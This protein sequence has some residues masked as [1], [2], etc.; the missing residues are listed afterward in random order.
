MAKTITSADAIYMLT[1]PSIFPVPQQLQGFAADDVFSTDAQQVAQT[2]MGVDGL[3]SAGFVFVSVNQMIAL[4]ADSDSNVLFD[5]WQEAQKAA[6]T[7]F[8]AIGL[9]I[10]PS[11]QRKWSMTKGILKTY[12]P[13]PDAKATLQPR[14]FGIE[15][16]RISPAPV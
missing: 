11:L 16:E 13:L 2:T 9:V 4:Q 6:K 10:L 8:P 5:A 12:P 7:I 3:L 14:R 15:W 1:I